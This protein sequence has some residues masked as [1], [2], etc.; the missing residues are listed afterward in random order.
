[1]AWLAQLTPSA[2]Y[3]AHVLPALVVLG[4]GMGATGAP[5]M[6]TATYNVPTADTGVASAMVNTMQQVGGAVGASGLSTIFASA[7]SSYVHTHTP[8]P[9]L[10]STSARSCP[11]SK[12]E[13]HPSQPQPTPARAQPRPRAPRKPEAPA[14]RTKGE[15][16]VFERVTQICRMVLP[17][18]GVPASVASSGAVGGDL[19]CTDS[20]TSRVRPVLGVPR[21]LAHPER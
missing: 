5:A 7:V 19:A 16:H 9:R 20:L 2:S 11:A 3:G 21:K 18:Q 12:H 8:S 14:E 1:M 10:I 4:V 13:Q 17:R 15:S 6:F